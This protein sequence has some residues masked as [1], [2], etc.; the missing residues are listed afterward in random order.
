MKPHEKTHYDYLSVIGRTHATAYDYKDRRWNQYYFLTYSHIVDRM[1]G[2]MRGTVLDVGTSHGN[3]LSFLKRKGFSQFLGVELDPERARL[4]KQCGY[5]E[6]YNCDAANIPHPSA[7]IDVALSNDVFVHILRIED[8]IAVLKEVE[9]LLKPNGIFI[10]NHTVSNAFNYDG[11][12]VQEYCSFLSLHELTALVV[13]NTSLQISDIKPTYYNF[14]NS[15]PSLLTR[16]ARR[17]IQV[18]F[19]V[20]LLFYLDYLNARD[21]P[22]E[23][24]DTVYIKVKKRDGN[25]PV[26]SG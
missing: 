21:L 22:L 8:K 13:N 20:K 7:T 9:R 17:F 5:H 15:R 3:W 25:V 23:D 16:L 10:F 26:A 14:R 4:A 24:S 19:A 2:N 18:P 6:V 11:Y 12:H 1:I